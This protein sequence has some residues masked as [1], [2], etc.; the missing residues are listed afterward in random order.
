MSATSYLKD[1]ES[2]LEQATLD[3]LT[4]LLKK[5]SNTPLRFMS[6][7]FAKMSAKEGEEAPDVGWSS[8]GSAPEY[9]GRVTSAAKAAAEKHKQKHEQK[10]TNEPVWDAQAWLA[11]EGCANKLEQVLLGPLKK[12]LKIDPSENVGTVELELIRAI[13]NEKVR[14]TPCVQASE[15]NPGPHADSS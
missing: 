12:I 15:Q 10:A 13:A 14:A 11:A 2:L 1:N 8:E 6:E 3:G 5:Q 4:E 9:V 7:H